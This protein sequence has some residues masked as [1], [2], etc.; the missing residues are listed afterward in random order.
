MRFEDFFYIY[1]MCLNKDEF[2]HIYNRKLTYEEAFIKKGDY[3]GLYK[4]D[5]VYAICSN[6]TSP[7]YFVSESLCLYY[8][9]TMYKDKLLKHQ[10]FN[11][12]QI[13]GSSKPYGVIVDMDNYKKAYLLENV[14]LDIADMNNMKNA[15]EVTNNFSKMYMEYIDEYINTFYGDYFVE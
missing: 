9:L 8:F 3:F 11:N 12:Y 4:K 15:I 1:N 2:L 6:K 13:L 14:Q 10:A 7:C 5:N